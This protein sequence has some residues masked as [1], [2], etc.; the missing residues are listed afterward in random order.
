M[1]RY[2]PTLAL[3]AACALLIPAAPSF[4]EDPKPSNR[5]PELQEPASNWIR[6][7]SV[8][9]SPGSVGADKPFV[10]MA[11][12]CHKSDCD[13]RTPGTGKN[14][15]DY[16]EGST[17][18]SGIPV[19]TL[20]P[21]KSEGVN[22]P[23]FRAVPAPWGV[24]SSAFT[25]GGDLVRFF[26]YGKSGFW[27]GGANL[28]VSDLKIDKDAKLADGE[29]VVDNDEQ[30]ETG[31]P[32]PLGFAEDGAACTPAGFDQY[33]GTAWG[34]DQKNVDI[35]FL[36]VEFEMEKAQLSAGGHTARIH[37]G[38]YNGQPFSVMA[39][40]VKDGKNMLF[41]DRFV[42]AMRP[43]L[44]ATAQAYVNQNG[45]D[46]DAFTVF[47]ARFL[48]CRLGFA[49]AANDFMA[50][51]AAASGNPNQFV[52]SWREF[53]KGEFR[54]YLNDQFAPPAPLED[55]QSYD[56]KP[57]WEEMVSRSKDWL[58]TG[59]ISTPA[60][61][62]QVKQESK[63]ETKSQAVVPPPARHLESKKIEDAE[64]NLLDIMK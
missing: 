32:L 19:Y 45:G 47:E 14:R 35:F 51:A 43:E 4:A 37:S 38:N 26:A 8:P 53:I 23:Y 5:T 2:V 55:W 9:A 44:R 40:S 64:K 16:S 28:W 49:G 3:A 60:P 15:V 36:P 22:L 7:I 50:K 56:P 17:S 34:P 31:K 54:H 18:R 57:V 46:A 10:P 52:A 33:Y 62:P 58:N 6:L 59:K 41:A 24:E 42:K 30:R 12:W 63:P 48:H 20:I 39:D 29:V 25:Y 21:K 11:Y 1:N 61:P 13:M 27:S